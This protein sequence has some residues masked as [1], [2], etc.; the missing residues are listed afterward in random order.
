VTSKVVQ[1]QKACD[2]STDLD[3]IGPIQFLD[4]WW[5]IPNRAGVVI[6]IGSTCRDACEDLLGPF[7]ENP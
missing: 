7:E 5:T 1:L 3:F 2:R 4:G 6:G